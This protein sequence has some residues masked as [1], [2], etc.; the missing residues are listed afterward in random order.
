MKKEWLFK[1]SSL[2]TMGL[3]QY[4]IFVKCQLH[5]FSVPGVLIQCGMPESIGQSLEARCQPA[6][7]EDGLVHPFPAFNLVPSRVWRLGCFSEPVRET[8]AFLQSTCRQV[9]RQHGV[10][11]TPRINSYHS[12]KSTQLNFK[13]QF[14]NNKTRRSYIIALES[15]KKNLKLAK[16]E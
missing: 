12:W 2:F 5:V 16:L 3:W 14:C 4:R 8:G 10:F 7:G 15:I 1:T 13:Y 11:M 6:L 9:R